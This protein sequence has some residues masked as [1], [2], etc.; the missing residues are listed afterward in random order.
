[1]SE[2]KRNPPWDYD[3]IILA[4]DFYFEHSPSIPD[5]QSSEVAELSSTLRKLAKRLGN[6][7]SGDYRNPNGV[8][9]K[10]MNFKSLDPAYDGAG[11]ASASAK[12][13]EVF[14]AYGDD[15]KSLREAAA[16]IYDGAMS[17]EP[18][19]VT[20]EPD[21]LDHEAVEGKL[22]IRTHRTRE[23]NVGIINKKKEAVRKATGKLACEAC[24]F[25]YEEK[26]G[27]RG[28]SFIECHHTVPVSQLRP[29]Q[30]TK[31]S[32]LVVLCANCHRMVHRGKHWLSIDEL[33]EVVLG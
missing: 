19:A 31:L 23:R 27:E 8:Y 14:E 29:G 21:D 6:A 12:D 22:L 4:L 30:K 24:G 33:Q 15:L 5:K 25:D 16:A 3:E 10:L 11:L 1:M 7:V 32:D 18:I 17:D 9:M 26:Y 13:R 2:I 28:R 20:D